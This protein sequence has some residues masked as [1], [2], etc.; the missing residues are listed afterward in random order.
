MRRRGWKRFSVIHQQAGIKGLRECAVRYLLKGK[1]GRVISLCRYVISENIND[2][3]LIGHGINSLLVLAREDKARALLIKCRDCL[4]S[5]P[6]YVAMLDRYLQR[7][8]LFSSLEETLLELKSRLIYDVNSCPDELS[9]FSE[10]SSFTDIV[11]VSNSL[12]LSFSAKEKECMLAMEK[13][14]FI[15]FNIGNPILCYSRG[16]FYPASA[17][18]LLIG[19]YQHIVDENHRLIFQPLMGRRFLGCWVRIER[20]WH[21]HW[22]NTWKRKFNGANSSVP[23]RELKESLLIEALYPLSLASV[24]PGKLVKRIPT[25]GSIALALVDVLRDI[26]GSS[27]RDVWAA[28]FSLSPSYIFE[29]CYGNNLHDF[30]FEKLALESRIANGTLKAIGSVVHSRPEVGARQHLSKA[31]LLVEKLNRSL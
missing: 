6:G 7:H 4:T 1:R 30:P 11:L 14:L 15:Y 31:G 12:D 18:E 8:A 25:I 13:P 20:Q 3:A 16:D 2:P 5:V 28:G 21:T 29:A 27:V 23:C 24:H 10:L 9:F 19:S 22:R 17:S 26:P